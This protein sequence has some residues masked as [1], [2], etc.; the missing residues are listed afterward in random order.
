MKECQKIKKLTKQFCEQQ[1]QQTCHD[2]TRP[3]QWEGKQQVAPEGDKEEGM[4]FHNAK[5]AFEAVYGHSE[6][7][8]DSSNNKRRKQLHIMY[9]GSS[10]ITSKRIIKKLRWVVAAV[11]PTSRAVP[12]HQWMETSI[13]FNASNCPKNMEGVR[14]LPMVISPT[15]VNVR[16]YH[17]LID[18][19][20]AINLISL[21]AFQKLQ[22]SMSRLSPSCLFLGVGLGSIILC[23]SISL[24]MTFEMPKNY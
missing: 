16:L 13:T 19:G 5:R 6:F 10:E 8:S 22:I 17:V 4:E 18:G 24:P 15:I 23:G 21:V 12:H 7:D 1:K 3:R 14:Q 9:D 11:A 20:A 2:G